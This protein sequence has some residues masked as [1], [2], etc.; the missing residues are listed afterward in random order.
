MKDYTPKNDKDNLYIHTECDMDVL[1]FLIQNHFGEDVDMSELNIES[2]YIHCRF[3]GYDV[4]D[5]NDYD[6]Y[7]VV[8]KK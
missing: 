1:I 7:I 4:Y 5:W 8:R 2:E 3:I 6:N